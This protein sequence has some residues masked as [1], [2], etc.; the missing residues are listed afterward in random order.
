[1]PELAKE[2]ANLRK[3]I[4]LCHMISLYLAFFQF[5]FK[6]RDSF[7]SFQIENVFE[8]SFHYRIVMF[9]KMPRPQTLLLE[10]RP[11]KHKIGYL[12]GDSGGT[13]VF[14]NVFVLFGLFAEIEAL[15][16]ISKFTKMQD[17]NQIII[18]SSSYMCR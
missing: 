15:S 9:Q 17:H 13:R 18:S 10:K 6:L 1:M 8:Y 16:L 11:D 2:Q 4:L 12:F 5:P 7:T 14:S 3:F